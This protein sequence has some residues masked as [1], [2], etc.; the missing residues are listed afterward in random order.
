MTS[1]ALQLSDIRIRGR[2]VE[3]NPHD[4]FACGELNVH[5]LQLILHVTEELCWTELTLPRRFQGWEGIAHGGIVCTILDELMAWSI[6][7]GDS[8]AF[9]ARMS[10]DFRRPIQIGQRIRAEGRLVRTRRRLFDTA[11]RIIA[12][13]GGEVLAT[14]AATYVAA[15][16][17]Q[18]RALKERY[19]FRLVQETSDAPERVD[20]S[21]RGD[22]RLRSIR[23]AAHHDDLP[24]RIRGERT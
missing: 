1:D 14:A 9:T 23:N 20:A 16:E 22:A 8:W 4:C 13:D 5:G 24:A 15:R 17:D 2:R 19:G 18:Q 3:L 10:V 12:V 6:V 11:A 21:E 7:A